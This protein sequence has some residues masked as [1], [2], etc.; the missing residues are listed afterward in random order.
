MIKQFKDMYAIETEKGKG[1]YLVEV[2][3]DEDTQEKMIST[4]TKNILDPNLLVTTDLKVARRLADSIKN[5]AYS[6]SPHPVK[7]SIQVEVEEVLLW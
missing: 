1:I 3:T 4:T 5:D 6:Y 7:V 2:E